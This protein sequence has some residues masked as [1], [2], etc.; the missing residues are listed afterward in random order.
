MAVV[1]VEVSTSLPHLLLEAEDV[2]VK[3]LW[4]AELHQLVEGGGL[5]VKHGLVY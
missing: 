3:E 1:E 2:P 4:E 5:D